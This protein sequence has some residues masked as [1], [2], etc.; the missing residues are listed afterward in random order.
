M[1][2]YRQLEALGAVLEYG[3]FDK[4]ADALGL[5]QSAVTQRVKQ[6]ETQVGKPVLIR[7]N[8]PEVTKAGLPLY[9]HFKKIRV[10]EEELQNDMDNDIS[11]TPLSI[12]VN[13]STLGSWFLPVLRHIMKSTLIDLHVGEAKVVHQLLQQG[14]IAGCISLRKRPSRGCY[15]EYLGKLVLRCVSTREFK[16]QYFPKGIGIKEMQETPAV[17]FHAESQMLRLYQKNVMGIAPFD[18]PT[19]VIPSQYEYLQMI[20]NGVAYG[21]LPEQL[22]KQ[23]KADKGLIDLS[24]LHPIII[25]QYWHRWGIESE[26]LESITQRLREEARGCLQL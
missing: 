15:V 1:L 12:G 22:F 18:V 10:L 14:S 9:T 26:L 13:A 11:G 19:H 20:S 8:P 7:T 17:L 24:P 4:A 5:T 3:G 16:Q 6:L 25:P 21:F 23:V 2:E